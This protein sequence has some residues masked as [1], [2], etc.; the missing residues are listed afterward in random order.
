LSNLPRIQNAHRVQFF[1]VRRRVLF[2]GPSIAEA[3]VGLI[4][5]CDSNMNRCIVSRLLDQFLVARI[6]PEPCACV[7]HACACLS[8]SRAALA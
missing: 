5:C 8:T 1:P 7:Q 6:D 4:T 2:S 3:A